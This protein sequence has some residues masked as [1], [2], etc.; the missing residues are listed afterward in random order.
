MQTLP[1]GGAMAAGQA[2]EDDVTPLLTGQV[3]IA[4]VNGPDAVVV[5]G[6]EGAVDTVTDH[7]QAAGRRVGRLR[8]SHAFHSPL[9]EPMLADFGDVAGRLAYT[10]PAIPIVST[11]DRPA[12]AEELCTSSPTAP[13]QQVKNQARSKTHR[14]TST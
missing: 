6:A 7:F 9:V 10:A 13:N 4:A 3:G 8:V 2:S 11:G 14:G 1:P 5:S 12:T